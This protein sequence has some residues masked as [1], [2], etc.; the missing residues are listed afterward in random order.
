MCGT[1][2]KTEMMP[3]CQGRPK[4]FPPRRSKR[5][6]TWAFVLECFPRAFGGAAER[7]LARNAPDAMGS[8]EAE[9]AR[10]PAPSLLV[11]PISARS[12]R[13]A[14]TRS[15]S[16]RTE[17]PARPWRPRKNR[18]RM[19]RGRRWSHIS[20]HCTRRGVNKRICSTLLVGLMTL[21]ALGFVRAEGPRNL[22]LCSR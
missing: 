13:R 14:N 15:R 20:S 6:T 16:S 5:G 2:G 12:I 3:R 18:S 1:G 7:S 11:R 9:M 19:L 21:I 10:L 17:F 8:T 4:Q 22:D